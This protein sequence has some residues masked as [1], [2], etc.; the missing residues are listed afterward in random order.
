MKEKILNSKYILIVLLIII[1][2]II[3]ILIMTNKKTDI[4]F[5]IKQI[6]ITS[7]ANGRYIDENNTE[8]WNLNL[9]QNNDVYIK[10]G[11]VENM[12]KV[13]KK[14]A[15]IEQIFIENFNVIEKPNLGEI[16]YYK[17][18]EK[19]DTLFEYIDENIVTDKLEFTVVDQNANIKNGQINKCEGQISMS[20]VNNNIAQYKSKKETELAFDGTLLDKAKIEPDDIKFKVSFDLVIIT[21]KN[22]TYKTSLVFDLPTGNIQENGFELNQNVDITQSKFELVK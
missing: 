20:I 4:P 14:D 22:R 3:T 18:S 1:L 10:F 16:S 2:L 11:L 12:D 7:T 8:N 6:Y 9:F 17:L 21:Q 19:E 15:I 5:E 13:D